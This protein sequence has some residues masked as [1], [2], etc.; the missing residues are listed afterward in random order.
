MATGEQTTVAA[1]SHQ[2]AAISLF[3]PR[4]FQ[5]LLFL[6]VGRFIYFFVHPVSQSAT[7]L[8]LVSLL[9]SFLTLSL[10]LHFLFTP[11]QLLNISLLAQ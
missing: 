8:P 11:L 2:R 4:N 10:P 5:F 7:L 6:S 1:D 9:F 3:S